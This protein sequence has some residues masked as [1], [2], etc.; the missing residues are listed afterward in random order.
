MLELQ[1]QREQQEDEQ[2]ERECEREQKVLEREHQVE[3]AKY[4]RETKTSF[5]LH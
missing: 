2:V 3:L 4:D 5:Q 1:Q